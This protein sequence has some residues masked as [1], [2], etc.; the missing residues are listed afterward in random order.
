MKELICIVCPK[1][2]HLQVDE[3]RDYAVSGN[4]CPRG[5]EY[6]RTELLNPTRV[7]TSIVK[8]EGAIHSCCPVKT[9]GAV[10]KGKIFECMEALR[11]IK[12][13][14]PVEAGIP[15]VKDVCGTGV[16]WI[17]CRDM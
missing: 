11:S 1:G 8:I 6:G 13:E 3:E 7:L 12:L 14:S 9:N 17:T 4:E 10:P 5:E 15:V 16:D 2:C